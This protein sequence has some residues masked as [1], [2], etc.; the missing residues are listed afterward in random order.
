MVNGLLISDPYHS[1]KSFCYW[2][3]YD[4]ALKGWNYVLFEPRTY[5][6]KK[7]LNLQIMFTRLKKLNYH[8][9]PNSLLE[10]HGKEFSIKKSMLC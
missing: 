10:I 9:H 4:L 3:R 8:L 5:P 7:L 1:F 2:G 6:E